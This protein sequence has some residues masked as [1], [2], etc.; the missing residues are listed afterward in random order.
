M[1]APIPPPR[2]DDDE[3]VHWALSTA[4]ALWGRGEPTEALKWLR[5]AAE[6]ASDVNADVRALELFKAAAEVANHVKAGGSAPPPPPAPPAATPAPPVAAP[7]APPAPPVAAPPA[8]AA[9]P[10]AATPAPP[11]AHEAP[12]RPSM[13]SIDASR[14]PPPRAPRPPGSMFP[15]PLPSRPSVPAPPVAQAASTPIPSAPPAPAALS[16]SATPPV[17]PVVPP[18]P[19][20]PPVLPTPAP[21]VSTSTP[22]PAPTRPIVPAAPAA[23]VAINAAKAPAPQAIPPKRRRSFTGEPRPTE[24][25][26]ADGRKA[27]GA[28]AVAQTHRRRRTH[29]DDELHQPPV[30]PPPPP[31]RG[32]EATPVSSKPNIWDDL[33]EDTR[34]IS[35]KPT[36]DGDE[37]EQ[38]LARLRNAPAPIDSPPVA[39]VAP[40]ASVTSSAPPVAAYTAPV[41]SATQPAA[42]VTPAPGSVTSR[43][44]SRTGLHDGRSVPSLLA[45]DES[46]FG[47]PEPT[48]I[49]R[50]AVSIHD[51][52]TTDGTRANGAGVAAPSIAGAEAGARKRLD[53]LPSLRVA[54]LATG[55]AG[56]VRLISLDA[57]D[58]PPPGAALAVLVPLSSADGEAVAR[59]FGAI[60]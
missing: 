33:D 36:G 8:P 18:T 40:V 1:E 27:A 48:T 9:P 22:R 25:P 44:R 55:V 60:E 53:T 13:P 15:P 59:L 51:E 31:P 11:P 47:G 14:M 26:R 45:T 34:V 46:S 10:V 3:D 43:E 41:Q 17:R 54:V 58:E 21:V 4:V 28:P 42:S 52:P 39:S 56:E 6:Q 50:R 49:M 29:A 7:A 32:P 2:Q 35:G 30:P 12:G 19:A 16:R 5:R 37:V 57:G 24:K 20:A 38:A 23:Q